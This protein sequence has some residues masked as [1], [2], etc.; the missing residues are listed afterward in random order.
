MLLKLLPLQ[1]SSWY[2]C[3]LFGRSDTFTECSQYTRRGWLSQCAQVKLSGNPCW[4][5]HFGVSGKSLP[6]VLTRSGE[7]FNLKTVA[8]LI[9]SVR[10]WSFS[11]ILG[12]CCNKIAS[13]LH[14]TKIMTIACLRTFTV[15]AAL[16]VLMILSATPSGRS[17]SSYVHLT[18]L[19]MRA[20]S[21]I[22]FVISNI[23]EKTG[24]TCAEYEKNICIRVLIC[25]LEKHNCAGNLLF[26]LRLSFWSQSSK[27]LD[28]DINYKFIIKYGNFRCLSIRLILFPNLCSMYYR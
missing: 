27:H 11:I 2:Y 18:N 10:S 9:V 25:L 6:E 5:Q 24:C 8:W 28:T 21:N 3:Y 12:F 13:L 23:T 7:H 19:F 26:I 20:L 15:H 17:H 16:F 1:H 14:S 22:L 4:S